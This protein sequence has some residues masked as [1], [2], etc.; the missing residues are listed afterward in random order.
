MKKRFYFTFL[1]L[2]VI[3]LALPGIAAK[4]VKGLT[5]RRVGR[6]P[7]VAS[8]AARGRGSAG[9]SPRLGLLRISRQTTA[10]RSMTLSS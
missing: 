1:V 8:G 9:R 3:L 6:R 4:A 5:V 2:A 10:R 7:P